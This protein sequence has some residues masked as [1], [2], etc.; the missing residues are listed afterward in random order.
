MHDLIIIG[1][2]A[3]GMSAAIYAA[4]Y[5]LNTLLISKNIGG[6]TLDSHNI[7]NYP[8]FL[9]ISGND[10]MNKFK[11]HV[12]FYN[13][14]IIEEEVIDIKNTFIICTKNKEYKA[15]AI[16]LALGRQ[17]RKLNIQGEKEFLG[18]GVSYC[19]TCDAPFFK[20][21]IIAVVGGSDSAGV[22]ALLLAEYAKKVYIVY[23][24]EKLRAEPL[25]LEKIEQNKKIEVIYNTNII[26]VKGNKFV[27][28]VILDK[29]Y[30]NSKELKL[31]GLFI[32]IG[33]I[34]S[35]TLITRLKVRLN[36]NGYII[37]N[38]KQET[39]VSG[40]FAAGDITTGTTGMKQVIT[41]AAQGAIAATSAY[42]YLNK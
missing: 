10:L 27:N 6:L 42:K 41:A 12:K 32:E 3:A 2:G 16:I 15:R 37:V 29:E 14:P 4:R 24:K 36:D 8:G 40:V 28:R 5:K 25:T 7:Q 13:V 22:E 20:D 19:A 23:R 39:N 30:N 18:K 21:K 34:P 31:D 35:T 33:S 38:E 1:A 11:E 26:E 9:S 17:K